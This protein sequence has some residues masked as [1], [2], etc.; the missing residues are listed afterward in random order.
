MNTEDLK[1]YDFIVLVDKSGSM[2][3]TDCP[4]GKSRWDYAQENVLAIARECMKY[5]SN[6]ITVGVFNNKHKLYENVTDGNDMLKK[7]FQENSPG[8]GTDT[9]GA[10]KFV[11]DEYLDTRGKTGS[12]PI[13]CIVITDGIPEDEP[14]LVKVIVDAT[15]KIDTREEIGLE[16]VQIGKDEHAKA[17]LHRLDDN[18]TK[19]GAKLDIVNATTCDDLGDEPIVDI[20]IASLTE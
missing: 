5:D 16:F 14:A 3:E 2:S 13:V 10:V 4:G 11:I 6:G 8:G 18:L 1:K 12:K 9:A 17:F 20:L 19:E 15:K 7:I